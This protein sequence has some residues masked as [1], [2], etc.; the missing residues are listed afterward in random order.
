MKKEQFIDEVSNLGY[1]LTDKQM[2]QF[3][4][5]YE[6]LVEW[7]EKM[8]LTGITEHDEVYLKHF[9]DSLLLIKA[10]KDKREL[11]LCDVGAGAGFPSV[12]LKIV[13]PSFD[14]TIIDSLNKRIT[15]L[16]HVIN[17]LELEGIKAIHARAE[18]YVL[19]HRESFD[20]VTARAVARLNILSE[21]CIPF[22]KVG[23]MFIAMKANDATTEIKEANQA[24]QTL[25]CKLDANIEELLP[26]ENSK[27]HI[28]RYKK[29]KKTPQKYPRNFGRIKKKPL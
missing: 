9:Y 11:T 28:I 17:E 27:R 14:V 6:L 22:V 16:N 5:Y 23:G 18:E 29:I 20:L 10:L 19:T 3:E 8:N 15:F 7:N 24:I 21:L 25:G 1:E 12:P 2:N 26:I 4:K 13:D